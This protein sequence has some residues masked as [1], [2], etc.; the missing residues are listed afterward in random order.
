MRWT[1]LPTG[2]FTGIDW[3]TPGATAGF[4]PYLVWAEAGQFRRLWQETSPPKW[5]PLL[6][7]LAP[8][9][10]V[11]PSQGCFFCSLAACAT[12]LHLPC[13]AHGPAVL[14]GA[15]EAAFLQ[16]HPGGRHA[17]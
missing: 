3:A 13:G 6:L 14:H 2:P 10:S 17:A 11:A 9:V 16:A 7:E 1:P 5:L 12:G 8:G 4:D 15:R